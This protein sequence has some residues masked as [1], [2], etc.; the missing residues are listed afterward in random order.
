[1]KV[2][3]VAPSNGNSGIVPPWMQPDPLHPD[4]PRIWP[5]P[6]VPAPPTKETPK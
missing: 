2:N 3:I 5:M 6:P 1:M 4:T